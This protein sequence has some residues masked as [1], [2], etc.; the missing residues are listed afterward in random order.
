[1]NRYFSQMLLGNLPKTHHK[2]R[3][4]TFSGAEIDIN[5]TTGS[6]RER[7]LGYLAQVSLP[8][9]AKDIAEGIGSDAGRV[10]RI[11]QQLLSSDQ[12]EMIKV[13][14]AVKEYQ[15]LAKPTTAKSKTRQ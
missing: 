10:N 2:G 15:L 14:G 13:E 12:L 8:S 7:V 5:L 3:P 11:L 9:T 1:M 4:V 6:M